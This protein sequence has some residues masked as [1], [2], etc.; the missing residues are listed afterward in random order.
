MVSFTT[1]AATVS[2]SLADVMVGSSSVD[3]SS[4]GVG[5][6]AARVKCRDS[7]SSSSN[8]TP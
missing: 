3:S 7:K 6:S 5:V 2:S 1:V 4:L 8:E